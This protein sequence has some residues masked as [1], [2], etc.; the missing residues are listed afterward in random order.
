M[1]YTKLSIKELKEKCKKQKIS[2][3]SKLKKKELIKILEKKN[4]KI[5]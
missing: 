2:G 1:D 4:I 5:G 3:Y